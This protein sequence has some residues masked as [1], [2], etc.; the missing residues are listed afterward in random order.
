MQFT[1]AGPPHETVRYGRTRVTVVKGPDLGKVVEAAGKTQ[2][3]M[4][5]PRV[6]IDAAVLAAAISVYR[7]LKTNIGAVVAREN[8]ARVVFEELRLWRGR[9]FDFLCRESCDIFRRGR[10]IA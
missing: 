7:V 1:R 8:T 9:F 5:G 4:R 3:L 6:A 10:V 2:I